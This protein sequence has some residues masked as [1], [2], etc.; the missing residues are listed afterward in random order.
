MAEPALQIEFALSESDL[1][2]FRDRLQSACDTRKDADESV[3]D[4]VE[5][6][7]AEA[8]KNN[9][10]PFVREQLAKLKPLT[11]M[12]RDERW[13]LKGED[14]DRVLDALAYFVDPED[15]IPDHI[16]GVGFLDDAIMI[17]LVSRELVDEIEAYAEFVEHCAQSGASEPA[18]LAAQRDEL[19]ARM[20]RRRF[21]RLNRR[22]G[23][24]ARSPLSLF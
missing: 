8:L 20:R 16:P 22:S 5:A 2:Y 10:P 1:Q 21:A 17:E 6:M 9:P 23:G 7:A 18:D 12:L 19:Q 13:A 3:I 11:A 4:G 24:R 14:R 15:L